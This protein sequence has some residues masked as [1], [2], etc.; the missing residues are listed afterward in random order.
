MRLICWLLAYKAIPYHRRIET[1]KSS[2][3]K[4]GNSALTKQF[5]ITEGLKLNVV[6]FGTAFWASYKAIPYHR[7]IETQCGF[8]R[9]RIL[10]ILTKQFHITEGLKRQRRRTKARQR[11][12]TKQ[13]H[14]TEGLKPTTRKSGKITLSLTKQF[15]ITEGL[16]QEIYSNTGQKRISYKA[17]PYHRRIET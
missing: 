17:I 1:Y 16:K 10:G 6:F 8:L 7:R 4:V 3:V 12:L 15:H 5:H 13:F 9:N 11:L 2:I 14:I